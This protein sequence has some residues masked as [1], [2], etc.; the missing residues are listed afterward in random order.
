M[1]WFK[2]VRIYN[3][4]SSC[5]SLLINKGASI[6]LVSKYLEHSK[7]S[8]TLNIYTHMYTS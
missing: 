3:F 7:A 5:A 1:N 8:V 4:K 2:K 6:T